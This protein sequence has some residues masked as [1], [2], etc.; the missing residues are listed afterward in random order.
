MS[1]V[2]LAVIPRTLTRALGDILAN[3]WDQPEGVAEVVLSVMSYGSLASLISHGVIEPVRTR[4]DALTEIVITPLGREIIRACA[5]LRVAE[6]DEDQQRTTSDESSAL[7]QL[8]REREKW[9]GR[10]SDARRAD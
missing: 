8:S 3:V 7:E 1:D 6:N 9:M 4:G 10:R 2:R 5:Q